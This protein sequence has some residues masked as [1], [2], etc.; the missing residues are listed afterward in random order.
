MPEPPPRPP[1]KD[2]GTLRFPGDPLSQVISQISRPDALQDLQQSA[3][4][5]TDDLRGLVKVNDSIRELT[6]AVREHTQ[7]M[8]ELIRRL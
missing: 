4:R 6:A 7:V 5:F 2:P 1:K 3:T 8:K